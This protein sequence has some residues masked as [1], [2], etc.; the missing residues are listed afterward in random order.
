MENIKL[1]LQLYFRPASAMS[2]IIDKGSWFISAVFVLIV[3]IVF[4]ITINSRLHT[5]YAIPNFNQFYY[6]N[7]RMDEAGVVA[8]EQ[9]DKAMDEFEKA[10][11]RRERIPLL[12]DYFFRFFSFE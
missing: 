9:V 1:L 10:L 8:D 7:S 4:F 3:S 6:A 2:E 12:G 5:A 11:A